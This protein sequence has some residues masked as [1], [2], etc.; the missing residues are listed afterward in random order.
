MTQPMPKPSETPQGYV[1]AVEDDGTTRAIMTGLLEDLGYETLEAENGHEALEVV[2]RE[3]DRIDVIVLDKVMPELNGLE[4]VTKLKS[5]PGFDTIPV[6]MVTGSK[7]PEEIKEGIDAGVFYYLTKPFDDDVF[8]SVLTAAMSEAKRL[9][10]LKNE[11][12]KHQTSFGFIDQAS[13]TINKLE[14]AEDLACF[15]AVCFPSPG[16]ALPG[17]ASLLVNAVEHGNLGISYEEKSILLENGGW[18]S[19]VEKR[20]YEPSYR[21]KKVKVELYRNDQETKVII[22]DEGDGFDWRSYME[23]DPARALDN[24]GRGI[25]QANQIS[26]DE[27]VY[28]EK[29]NEVTAIS[30]SGSGIQW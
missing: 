28:N 27:I 30:R 7:E 20:Q 21:D 15:L 19:E 22:T 13:F 11:L 8:Q 10:I 29:G 1:L 9:Q 25:A 5:T 23:I 6:V 18:R 4:V 17:L 26:F 14:E 16:T 3:I 12:Q 24:N 2:A